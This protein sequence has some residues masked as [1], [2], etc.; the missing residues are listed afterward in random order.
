MHETVTR[1]HAQS[2]GE[3]RAAGARRRELDQ[4]KI[5]AGGAVNLCKRYRTSRPREHVILLA[6]A[7]IQ[8]F[9]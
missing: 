2:V 3:A 1:G 6:E 4:A 8:E 9:S 5:F 7:R